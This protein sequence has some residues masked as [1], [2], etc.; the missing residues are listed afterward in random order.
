MG[1]P[2][3][4]KKTLKTQSLMVNQHLKLGMVGPKRTGSGLITMTFADG[5]LDSARHANPSPSPDPPYRIA[6]E[7]ERIA[8]LCSPAKLGIAPVPATKVATKLASIKH[9]RTN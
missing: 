2:A 4:N 6:N 7:F 8:A 3:V 1:D 5:R 9:D